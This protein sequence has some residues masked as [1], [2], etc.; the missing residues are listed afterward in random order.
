M[1]ISSRICSEAGQV[2]LFAE[3][4]WPTHFHTKHSAYRRTRFFEPRIYLFQFFQHIL[5]T[6][7]FSPLW[8]SFAIIVNILGLAEEDEE[9][10]G[11]MI[12]S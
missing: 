2:D 5:I 9:D 3:K 7:T 12:S 8:D 10:A 6:L 1:G 4:Q 11:N